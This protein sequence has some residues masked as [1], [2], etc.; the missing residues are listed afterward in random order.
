MYVNS[1]CAPDYL[2]SMRKTLVHKRNYSIL[3]VSCKELLMIIRDNTTPFRA[4]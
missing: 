1:N 4:D 3:F 2:D